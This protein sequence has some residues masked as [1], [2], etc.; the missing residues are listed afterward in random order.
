[1]HHFSLAFAA[2]QA[3]IALTIAQTPPV[4]QPPVY[5][6]L[7][8]TYRTGTVKPPG[9]A[10]QTAKPPTISIPPNMVSETSKGLLIMLNINY[11]HS[12]DVKRMH[13]LHWLSHDISLS[14]EVL[15]IP[16]INGTTPLPYHQPTKQFL[17]DTAHI[18]TFLL[19]HQPSNFT[20]N[21]TYQINMAEK[22]MG[23][24]LGLWTKE[25]I[26]NG[27]NI[28]AFELDNGLQTPVAASYFSVFRK[29]LPPLLEWQEA[30]MR[31]LIQDVTLGEGTVLSQEE[32]EWGIMREGLGW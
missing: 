13:H 15:N 30:R 11:P 21:S 8:I 22:R 23:H 4:F 12:H 14:E 2:L 24:H 18:Y 19:Y 29:S 28:T 26:P 27:F 6:P 5:Q 20:L 17:G 16:N 9:Q 32:I 1:M 3:L 10:V 25:K 7:Y 31:K